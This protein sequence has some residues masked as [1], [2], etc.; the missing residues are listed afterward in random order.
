MMEFSG[1]LTAS[2]ALW[3]NPWTLLLAQFPLWLTPNCGLLQGSF[4]FD[5]R[6]ETVQQRKLRELV[7]DCVDG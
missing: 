2:L 5:I 3:A 1:G 7:P 6:S 4:H